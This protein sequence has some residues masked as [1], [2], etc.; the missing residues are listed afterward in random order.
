MLSLDVAWTT[1]LVYTVELTWRI[2]FLFIMTIRLED[3]FRLS[4]A[5]YGEV[6]SVEV[7]IVLCLS[8]AIC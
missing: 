6:L 7:V 5:L 2:K 3:G 1:L 8:F 4:G